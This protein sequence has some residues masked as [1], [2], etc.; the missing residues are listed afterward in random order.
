MKRVLE[1]SAVA[2]AWMNKTQSDARNAGGNFYFE[3]DTIYSYGR[4]FE[5]AK[6]VTNDNGDTAVLLTNRRYSNTTAKQVHIVNMA[7]WGKIINVPDVANTKDQN[8]TAWLSD[9]LFDAKCLLKAKKPEIYL[10]KIAG[11]KHIIE[12]YANF[13]GCDIPAQLT[14]ALNIGTAI[15]YKEFAD[16]KTD[17]E[18]AETAKKQAKLKA[19]HK[20]Q[21]AKWHQFDGQLNVY[22]GLS[23]LRF[24][25]EKNEI[26][27]SQRVCIPYETAKSF[28][29]VI[30][31]KIKNGG[32]S[33]YGLFMHQYNIKSITKDQIIVGC[34]TIK[35][36]EIT[37]IAKQ[38]N[39]V[40]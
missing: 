9:V 26:E 2:H 12:S 38:L 23:Y 17:Y 29:T 33:D 30:L 14:A 34:H 21:L 20:K 18:K 22:D 37:R 6:H 28:F 3:G 10:S 27:T 16:K 5:I 39:W 15:E 25:N 36:A 4:H 32:C 13:F 1:T 31:H 40:N 7:I 24:N 11:T 35:M 19:D 8:F